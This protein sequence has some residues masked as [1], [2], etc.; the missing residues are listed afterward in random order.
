MSYGERLEDELR[1]VV[2]VFDARPPLARLHAGDI[3]LDH[4]RSFLQQ[5]YHLLRERHTL[6]ALATARLRAG[7]DVTKRLLNRAVQEIR[8]ELLALEDLEALGGDR[9]AVVQQPP[10]P[11]TMGVI[12]YTYYQVN[13]LEP[14]GFLGCMALHD[15][16]PVAAQE[17]YHDALKRIGLPDEASNLFKDVKLLGPT[18][19]ALIKT[20]VQELVR[21][22]QDVEAV[23]LG[24]R[25]YAALFANMLG[26][27]FD[28][29]DQQG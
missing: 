26:A 2:E 23:V 24:M 16:T 19:T 20:Y 25:N 10:L 7:P 28:A 22:E 12:A 11:E 6:L 4:F 27:A 15:Y 8:H 1:S 18:Y 5:N 14:V 29:V 9:S 21:S 13:E 17:R 3:S